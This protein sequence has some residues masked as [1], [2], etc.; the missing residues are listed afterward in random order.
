MLVFAG[1]LVAKGGSLGGRDRSTRFAIRFVLFRF[2]V[3]VLVSRS[4]ILHGDVLIFLALLV[5]TFLPG[6]IF[7]LASACS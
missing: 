3:S 5:L 4:L 6:Q 2:V 7:P 1:G